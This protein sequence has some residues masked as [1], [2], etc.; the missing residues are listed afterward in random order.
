MTINTVSLLSIPH[1]VLFTPSTSTHQEPT[2]CFTM[3]VNTETSE[4]KLTDPPSPQQQQNSSN[5]GLVSSDQLFFSIIRICHL[6]SLAFPSFPCHQM[7]NAEWNMDQTGIGP[8]WGRDREL[9]DVVP[10]AI[11]WTLCLLRTRRQD[12]LLKLS[13]TDFQLSEIVLE[14]QWRHKYLK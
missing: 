14:V 3:S 6:P 2:F 4:N 5:S 12:V 9:I 13:F 11:L 10:N 1:L 8:W 7:E